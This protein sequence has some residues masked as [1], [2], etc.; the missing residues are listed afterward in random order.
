MKGKTT[1]GQKI[2]LLRAGGEGQRF[3]SRRLEGTSGDNENGN[4]NCS[5]GYMTI[6]LS[7]LIEVNIL[8]E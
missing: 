8:K 7:K 2:R 5:G 3:T 1:Q 6:C 4:S